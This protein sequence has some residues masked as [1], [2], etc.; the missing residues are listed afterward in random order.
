MKFKIG[1]RVVFKTW[2]EM[3]AEFGTNGCLEIMCKPHFTPEMEACIDKNRVYTIND[4]FSR[5]EVRL[6]EFGYRG[7]PYKIGLDMLKPCYERDVQRSDVKFHV[8][9]KV[10][11]RD[12]ED[13]EKE[14]GLRE[15]GAIKCRFPFTY[16]K[17]KKI[18]KTRVYTIEKILS[19]GEVELENFGFIFSIS[20]DMIAPLAEVSSQGRRILKAAKCPEF[21]DPWLTAREVYHVINHG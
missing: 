5:K 13:M 18:D 19:N 2:E 12:W 3:K 4:I 17:E 7:G 14:F 8:G 1:D 6:A 21:L 9:D 16:E 20:L 10:V 11:F 15:D